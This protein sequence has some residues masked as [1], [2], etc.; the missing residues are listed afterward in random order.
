MELFLHSDN[1]V[2]EVG[3]EGF[4][5][6][7]VESDGRLVVIAGE[8]VVNIV[9]ASWSESDFGEISGPYSPICVFGLILGEIGGVNSV[10][11]QSVSFV[12]FLIVVLFEVVVG[13]VD[14]ERLTN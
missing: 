7:N 8:D 12:P 1:H 13:R 3:I 4:A 6:G 9:L 11:D 14:C 2:V 10:V 5:L